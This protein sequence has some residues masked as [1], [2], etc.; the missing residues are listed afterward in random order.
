MK[1]TIKVAPNSNFYFVK[2]DKNNKTKI[3]TTDYSGSL[4]FITP[5]GQA[6]IKTI[7]KLSPFHY[8]LYEDINNDNQNE[9]IFIDNNKL[10]EYNSGLK[11][12]CSFTAPSVVSDIP[13]IYKEATNKLSIGFVC[14]KINKIYLVKPDGSLHEGFPMTGSTIFS[15]TSLNNDG[16][17]N[18]I[19]GSDRTVYN[20]SLSNSK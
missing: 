12:T 2:T 8:F 11:Q 10:S 7:S 13:I 14:S 19:V 4:V 17:L 18:L 5:S 16:A 6:E 20:Y 1:S 3:L 9:Y 15:I